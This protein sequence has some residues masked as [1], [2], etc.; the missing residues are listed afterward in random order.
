M[1]ENSPERGTYNKVLD[2]RKIPIRGLWVR[3]ARYYARLNVEDPV[4]GKVTNRWVPLQDAKTVAEA[5]EALNK[6]KLKRTDKQ[7][8]R[9]GRKSKFDEYADG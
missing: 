1:S 5:R 4:T 2:G 9:L 7:P 8:P 6:L 3:N